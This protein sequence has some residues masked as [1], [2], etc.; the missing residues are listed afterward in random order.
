[1]ATNGYQKYKEKLF[2]NK[3]YRKLGCLVAV[4]CRVSLVKGEKNGK[5]T[6][7]M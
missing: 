1:M 6:T 5:I 2:S 4:G 3:L 7:C